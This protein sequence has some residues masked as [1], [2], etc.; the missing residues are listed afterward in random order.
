MTKGCIAVSTNHANTYNKK[1]FNI[2]GVKFTQPAH[3]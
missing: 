1:K 3:Q 2:N